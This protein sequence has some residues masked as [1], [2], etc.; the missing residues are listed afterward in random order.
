MS[1]L[2]RVR[3]LSGH[4]QVYRN[5]PGIQKAPV[6]EPIIGAVSHGPKKIQLVAGFDKIVVLGIHQALRDFVM[7]FA[8]L[9]A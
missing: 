2:E 3:D 4:R 7:G 6:A 8:R 1:G 9:W 5:E